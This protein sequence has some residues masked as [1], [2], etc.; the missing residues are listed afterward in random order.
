MNF[1]HHLQAWLLEK[2]PR[3]YLRLKRMHS[4]RLREHPDF[5]ALHAQLLR[6][7]DCIMTLPERYNLWALTRRL[8]GR[9][10]ALAE[11]GVY[12]GGSA[13]LLAA[14][15]G[16]AAPLH[17]FDTFAGMPATEAQHDG[18]FQA[19]QL[20]DT[21]LAAVQAKLRPWPNVHFHAGFFPATAQG[22]PATLRYKLVHV[23]VD[24]RSSNLAAL[25]FF[26]PR[27]LPGGMIVLHDYNE[28]SVPGTH[29]AVEA[30][31]RDKPET[32]IELWH[33]QALIVKR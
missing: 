1:G 2:H 29:A 10:G 6:S 30:F 23:D 25:E 21:T 22:E 32:L 18:R 31:M 33:T 16:D 7:G 11:V 27:L 5:L 24:I 26:Y 14:A 19:G 3:V 20:A 13:L 28:T 12:R 15:K 9:P 8:Q 17:L 4:L